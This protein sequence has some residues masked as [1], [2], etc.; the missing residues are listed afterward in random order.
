MRTERFV[1]IIGIQGAGKTFLA[2]RLYEKFIDCEIVWIRQLNQFPGKVDQNE[3]ISYFLDDLFYELQSDEEVKEVKN[4]IDTLYE[5][6]VVRGNGQIF[7]TITSLIWRRHASLFNERKYQN[8]I[9]L[10]QLCPEDREDIL[11]FHMN[12]SGIVP[13]NKDSEDSSCPNVTEYDNIRN[14]VLKDC[15]PDLKSL[16]TDRGMGIASSIA[17]VCQYQNRDFSK[18]DISRILKTPLSW[19][20]SYWKKI[21][22]KNWTGTTVILALMVIQKEELDVNKIDQMCLTKIKDME[23]IQNVESFPS[24]ELEELEKKR[25]IEKTYD[26]RYR[27]QVST[28]RKVL[29]RAILQK[30]PELEEFCDQEMLRRRLYRQESLPEDVRGNYGKSFVFKK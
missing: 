6:T 23:N 25:L 28:D 1:V 30:H 13:G 11:K 12:L 27:F 10:D 2:N 29:L 19:L 3:R 5:R 24:E 15:N 18:N 14:I 17:F 8:C 22:N 4:K 7:L 16:V 20:H 9:D 26:D 21:I